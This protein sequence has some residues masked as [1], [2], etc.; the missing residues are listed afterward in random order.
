[1]RDIRAATNCRDDVHAALLGNGRVEFGA[2]LVHVHVNVVA[3]RRSRLAQA[4]SKARPFALE[5][6][7]QLADGIRLHIELPR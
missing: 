6:V 5:V 4:I 1:V 3:K 7:D 2:L